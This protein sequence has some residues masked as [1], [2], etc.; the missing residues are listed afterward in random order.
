MVIQYESLETKDLATLASSD[1]WDF[2]M[3]QEREAGLQLGALTEARFFPA[4][5]IMMSQASI[6][7]GFS[8][9]RMV[10]WNL[11]L[12]TPQVV[13]GPLAFDR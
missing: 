9:G 6:I 1:G 3:P 4:F 8:S 13:N 11:D 7:L 5:S 12:S 2:L 10:K